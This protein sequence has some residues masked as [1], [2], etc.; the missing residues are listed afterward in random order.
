MSLHGLIVASA[1]NETLRQL[2]DTLNSRIVQ[3]R[4]VTSP[5]RFRDAVDEHLEIVAALQAGDAEGAADA[6]G[7]HLA[8]AR[9]GLVRLA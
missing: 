5:G 8:S 9:Q 3:V 1:G 4:V 7:R 2:M 6:M